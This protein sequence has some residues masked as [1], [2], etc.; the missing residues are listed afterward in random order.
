MVEGDF[1]LTIIIGDEV[2]RV[3]NR[4]RPLV[5]KGR[6]SFDDTPMLAADADVG[7]RKYFALDFVVGFVFLSCQFRETFDAVT[8]FCVMVLSYTRLFTEQR[9]N[10]L[11]TVARVTVYCSLARS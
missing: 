6:K 8:G 7:K 5:I 11:E 3:L 10:G 1:F 4:R 9:T 2:G